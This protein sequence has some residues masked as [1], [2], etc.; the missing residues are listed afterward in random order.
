MLVRF[1]DDEL[2]RLYDDESYHPKGM[3]RALAK[4]F[5]KKVAILEAAENELVLRQ[6][7]SLNF[8]K[9]KGKSAGQYSIRLNDQ[10]RLIFVFLDG[11][12]GKIALLIEVVDYH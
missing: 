8:K 7:R 2:R 3:D 11:G 6:M 4:A 10:W 1:A 5:R 12:S 9:L